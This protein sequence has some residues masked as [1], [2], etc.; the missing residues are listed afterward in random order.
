[1]KTTEQSI[2]AFSA[3]PPLSRNNRIIIREGEEGGVV[4]MTEFMIAELASH[5]KLQKRCTNDIIELVK[6]SDFYPA[7]IRTNRIQQIEEAIEKGDGGSI[8]KCNLG[9]EDDGQQDLHLY[10]RSLHTILEDLIADAGYAGHQYL[11]FEL[12][13]RDGYRVFGPANSTVWWQ[14]NAELIGPDRVLIGLAAYI[15]ESWNK[16]NMTCESCYGEHLLAAL[17]PISAIL[18]HS[19]LTVTVLN[20]D[21]TKRFKK[22]GNRFWGCLPIYK[23]AAAIN[24][25]R[26][27]EWIKRREAEMNRESMAV[28]VSQIRKLR[29]PRPWLFADG[30]TRMGVCRLAYTIGDQPAQDKLLSKLTKGCSVCWAGAHDLDSTERVWPLRDSAKLLRSMRRVAAECL[31]DE[32]EVIYGKGKVIQDWEKKHRMRFGSNSVLELLDLGFHCTLFTPRCFLHHIVI[33]LFGNHIIRA[34]IYLIWSFISLAIYCQAYG[35]RKAPAKDSSIKSVLKRWAK[36]LSSVKGDE[37]CLTITEEF[38]QHFRK[39]FEEGKSSFTG[40]RMIQIMLVLPYMLRD[41]AGPE[42]RRINDAISSAVPGDPLYGQ[43]LVEDPCVRIVETLI[44]FLHWF[45]LVRRRELSVKDI[46][47]LTNRGTTMMESLKETF[48]EKSGEEAAWCFPKFHNVVHIPVWIMLFGWI[49]NFSGQHGERSH[50]ELLKSLAHCINNQQVFMQYLRFWER[51]EQLSRARREAKQASDSE[52]DESDLEAD[53]ARAKKN[54]DKEEAMHACELGIRCPLFFMALHRKELH[55]RATGKGPGRNRGRQRFNV[56]VL[57]LRGGT[58]S[59][60]VKDQPLLTRLPTALALFAYMYARNTLGLPVPADRQGKPLVEEVN[61]VLL[62]NLCADCR[63]NQLRTFSTVEMESNM[64]LG[65]QRVRCHPFSFDQFRGTNPR[66][67]VALIPPERYSGIPFRQFD[68]GN[69]RHREKM[70]VG[71]VELFFSASFKDAQ[72]EVTEYDLA[73]V[74]CLYDFKH[75]SAMGPLQLKSGARMF[76]VPSTPWTIVLPINHILGRVPLMRLYLEGSTE[77][78]IP[79]SYTRD[80]DAY[81]KRGSADRAG[82]D[83]VGTGSLLFELNV[84]LWQYGRPSPRT[85]TVSERWERQEKRFADAAARRGR[86]RARDSEAAAAP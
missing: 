59:Q 30:V 52:S 47:E 86:K 26:S 10:L 75:P 34:I 54:A 16:R 19:L 67:Y 13:E 3:L 85:M 50:R 62:R 35:G 2:E 63:G 39:V 20:N 58:Q 66:Q 77:P 29:K 21:E 1:M 57:R 71:R 36:R 74:S 69:S 68:L 64:C 84:H 8:L 56:F 70:W 41:I 6:R 83:N 51:V 61:S 55:H 12:L 32:G 60:S 82:K 17:Y 42:R 65:V 27:D 4:T 31:D 18:T 7:D 22:G 78:T 23:R 79:H 40:D 24:A 44:V 14:I 72:G 46:A 28:L 37:S 11:S 49:E 43:P 15:D 76:Y 53:D 80:K 9:T 81:F 45:F 33:G 5:H 48:P 73:F 38:S 25:G